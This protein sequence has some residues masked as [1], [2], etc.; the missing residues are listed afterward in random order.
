MILNHSHS[1]E[2]TILFTKHN[3]SYYE[4]TVDS[5]RN[6]T[7]DKL[8]KDF[9][10]YKYASLIRQYASLLIC[11]LGI[12]GNC[13]CLLV[14]FQNHNRKISCYLYFAFI[15]IAD[16]ILLINGGWY[17][18]MDDFFP[19]KINDPACRLTNSLWFGSSF[20]SAYILF[21]ATLDR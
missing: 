1:P 3:F 12:F 21:F 7:T 5:S 9:P 19:E 16:N 11:V 8:T 18:S 20:A 17:Q 13:L 15:A 10:E 14:L 4:V 6:I 2:E